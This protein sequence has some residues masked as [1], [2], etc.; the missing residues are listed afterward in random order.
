[1]KI[2]WVQVLKTFLDNKRQVLPLDVDLIDHLLNDALKREGLEKYYA[3]QVS[4][5]GVYP[6]AVEKRQLSE[7]I[8]AKKEEEP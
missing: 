8:R 4:A 3:V 7:L 6:G 1:L 5:A 2:L